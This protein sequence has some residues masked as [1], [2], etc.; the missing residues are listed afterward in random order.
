MRESRGYAFAIFG[1]VLLA[2]CAVGPNY[3][4][5][6]EAVDS[7]FVNASEPGLAAG[8]PEERY[9]TTFGDPLLTQLVE[10]SVMHN[11]DL[12]AATAN[13]QAAR[14]ARRLTGFD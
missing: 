1:A 3:H 11:T 8:D 5:P 6:Q 7:H 10:D 14:A 4:R 9:W 2:G 12:Q 13:L